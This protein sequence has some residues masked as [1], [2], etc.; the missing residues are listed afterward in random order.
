L[1][2]AIA[3]LKN[4]MDQRNSPLVANHL[5]RPAET[6]VIMLFGAVR[7]LDSLTLLCSNV[8]EYLSPELG[9][10]GS[11]F[12]ILPYFTKCNYFTKGSTRPTLYLRGGETQ[13]EPRGAL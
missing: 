4:V 9:R 2:E 3:T 13:R 7:L 5:Q 6:G 11:A 1:P 8:H 12:F 10:R